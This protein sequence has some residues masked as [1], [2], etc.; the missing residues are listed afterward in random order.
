MKYIIIIKK[1]EK[2]PPELALLSL[3]LMVRN[4][5]EYSVFPKLLQ[6]HQKEAP[7]STSALFFVT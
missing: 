4:S 6:F 1:S 2:N 5:M 7:N 3:V